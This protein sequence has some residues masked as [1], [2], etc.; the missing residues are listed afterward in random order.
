[1]PATMFVSPRK[2]APPEVSVAGTAGIVVIRKQHR[3]IARHSW[4]IQLEQVGISHHAY[5]VSNSLPSGAIREACL[6]AIANSRKFGFLSPT[7][8]ECIELIYFREYTILI[9]NNS[10]LF[11]NHNTNIMDEKGIRFIKRMSSP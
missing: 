7:W 11:K 2:L 5:A 3:E 4:C 8:H 6:E 1:M 10:G 9:Q